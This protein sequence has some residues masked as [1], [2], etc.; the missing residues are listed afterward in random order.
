MML[1]LVGSDLWIPVKDG[2]P[3]ARWLHRRHYSYRPYRDGRNPRL[4][5]GP[6]EKLVMLTTDCLALWVWR[7]YIS[8]DGETGVNNAD[9]RNEGPHRSSDLIRA[10]DAVGWRKWP[11]ARFYTYVDPGKVASPNPGYCYKQAGW[12]FLRKTKRG[13]HVLEMY[14]EWALGRGTE[15]KDG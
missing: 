13:L 4:F 10:A 3:R 8:D 12:R 7:R 15:A 2:D 5:V 11:G 9:F 14:P 1:P 6:G